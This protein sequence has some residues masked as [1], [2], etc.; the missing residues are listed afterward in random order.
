M[1]V[2]AD[3]EGA[4]PGPGFVPDRWLAEFESDARYQ[5]R[6]PGLQPDRKDWQPGRLWALIGA[7]PL[8]VILCAASLLWVVSIGSTPALWLIGGLWLVPVTAAAVWVAI[9]IDAVVEAVS[10]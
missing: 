5:V 9:H 3:H 4:Q 1:N 2:Y 7:S 8:A 6:V 10:R